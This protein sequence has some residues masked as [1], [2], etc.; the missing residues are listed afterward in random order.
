[1]KKTLLIGLAMALAILPASA[2]AASSEPSF[3]VVPSQKPAET[4]YNELKGV[5]A[6]SATNAYAVGLTRSSKSGSVYKGLI[7]HFNGSTWTVTPS[8]SVAAADTVYLNGVSATSASNVFAVGKDY[9][10]TTEKSKSL[11]EHFNGTEWTRV[12]SPTEEPPNATLNGVSADSTTDAWAV[13]ESNSPNPHEGGT[14]TLIEHFNGTKWSV[15]E[16][17]PEYPSSQFNRLGAVD[18]IAPN[19]V[20]VTGVTG[21]HHQPVIEH[22]NGS[23]WSVVEQAA[24]AS[25]LSSISGSSAND[26]WIV[27]FAGE[28]PFSEHFNGSEVVEVPVPAVAAPSGVAT[29]SEL[30][31]VVDLGP[32]NV[33]AVGRV[34]TEGEPNTPL[35]EHFNGSSWSIVQSP[36]VASTASLASVSGVAEGPVFA[37]GVQGEEPN[38]APLTIQN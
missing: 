4:N 5:A 13:G 21:K 17:A 6:V 20:W 8:A 11:I 34:Q 31:G 14:V 30:N 7:E 33:W 9:S 35:I 19:D 36:T 18:A 10:P 22:F 26:V 2:F 16:G 29:A 25:T 38:K 27:G 12:A 15:V 32:A 28:T 37:V 23:S 3:T 1:M 24:P